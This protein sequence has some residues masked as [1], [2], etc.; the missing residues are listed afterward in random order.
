MVS[1][2]ITI[3]LIVGSFIIISANKI[4]E[5][6]AFGNEH[7]PDAYCD[8]AIAQSLDSSFIARENSFKEEVNKIANVKGV[9]TSDRLAGDEMARAFNIHR[10][11]ENTGNTLSMR[12]KGI[13]FDFINVYRIKILAGR[14][15]EF[16]DYNADYNKLHNVVINQNA[17]KL[18]GYRSDNDA[19][20]KSITMFNKQ[21]DVIGVINR[22]SSKIICAM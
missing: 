6:A 20:G 9:A 10:S 12:N 5:C 15:F 7:K 2:L 4:Y 13:D 14:N 21:W 22:L 11:D 19:V 3:A 18:L 8:T 1:L 16:T 17:A